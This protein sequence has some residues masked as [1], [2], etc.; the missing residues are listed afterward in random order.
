MLPIMI[1]LVLLVCLRP[2]PSNEMVQRAE[3]RS[4]HDN[5]MQDQSAEI[6]SMLQ[7]IQQERECSP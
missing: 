2:A 7:L 4:S 5:V 6:R 1:L 3:E